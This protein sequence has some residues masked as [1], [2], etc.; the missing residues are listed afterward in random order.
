MQDYCLK[1]ETSKICSG[2]PGSPR[3]HTHSSGSTDVFLSSVLVHR[4]YPC[5][6]TLMGPDHWLK[7]AY[8]CAFSSALLSELTCQCI[9]WFL[10]QPA[11]IFSLIFHACIDH[12]HLPPILPKSLHILPYFHFTRILGH[13][14]CHHL[15]KKI[16]ACR[17]DTTCSWS[18]EWQ[19]HLA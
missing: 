15:Y 2:W 11:L 19:T 7:T 4:P 12:C 8:L 14:Y 5:P 16:N 17:V 18:S 3:L 6:A 9:K 13:N 1:V 10:K